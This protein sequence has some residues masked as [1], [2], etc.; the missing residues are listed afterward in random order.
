MG[1]AALQQII[2]AIGDEAFAATASRAV[3][4][5]MGFELASM[6]L[7]RTHAMPAVL[8]DEFGPA[9]FGEG[10]DNYV[11]V[12]HRINPILARGAAAGACRA[13]DFRARGL[14][15]RDDISDRLLLTDEE[16]LGFRT[17]GWP[18][19]LEEVGLY[20]RTVDGTVELSLYRER[21]INLA[22]A[23]KMRALAAL[24]M[25]LAAAFERHCALQPS[26]IGG[27]LSPRENEICDLMLAGCSS[28]AIALRLGI[29]AHTVKDHRKQVFRKLGVASLAELFALA[30]RH[31]GAP[32]WR[33]G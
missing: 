16:E 28:T 9:G 14:D 32:L 20:F 33:D 5:F 18:P 1:Q 21:G 8:F 25:P 23:G 4:E 12:T 13:R 29:T 22:T 27:R 7:H 3:R 11:H 24:R 31:D 2:G 30:G 10:L 26:R 17:V 6:L 15:I 19:R